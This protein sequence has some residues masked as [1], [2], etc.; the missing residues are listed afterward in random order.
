MSEAPTTYGT[1]SGRSRRSTAERGCRTAGDLTGAACHAGARQMDVITQA[2]IAATPAQLWGATRSR[3][4]VTLSSTSTVVL[5][6]PRG[7]GGRAR[8]KDHVQAAPPSAD[9]PLGDM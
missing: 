7:A 5:C 6:A 1:T 8:C 2:A 4:L 3:G 9:Q